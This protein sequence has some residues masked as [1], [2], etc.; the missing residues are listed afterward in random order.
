MTEI[1]EHLLKRSRERRSAIGQGGDAAAD[2]PGDAAAA[3]NVPA[4]TSATTAPAAAPAP[5]GPPARTAA[6][7]PA[8]TAPP[9]PDPV[10]VQAAK[11][12][13]KIPFWAMATLSLMPIWAFMYVRAV[14]EP[15]VVVEGPLG[16]GTEIYSSCAS[17]HGAEGGGGVGYPFSG[18]EVLKTFPHIEDQIRYVYYGTEGYNAASVDVYGNPDREGGPHVTGQRGIMPQFGTQLTQY[19]IVA[20][21]CHERYTLGGAD[22]TSE[23]YAEEYETWCS[24]ES[25]VFAELEAGTYDYT[26]PEAPEMGPAE[27]TPIGPEA[28]PG[29]P[30]SAG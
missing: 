6:P 29:S 20:V 24:E 28:V 5:A 4:T 21:V 26:S 22:P 18:G 25:A 7:A 23:E 10:Y 17:C 8:A 19:E 9:K 16:V 3:S 30:A 14:T 27:I 13:R 1:P 11:Q 12:R 2:A 15:P